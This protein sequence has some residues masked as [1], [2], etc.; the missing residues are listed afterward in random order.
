M[1]TPLLSQSVVNKTF[2]HRLTPISLIT[3]IYHIC[4]C[5]VGIMFS[6]D[7]NKLKSLY[8]A[9]RG[10]GSGGSGGGGDPGNEPDYFE[11]ITRNRAEL[12]PCPHVRG[13]IERNR[14]NAMMPVPARI[15]FS[16]T[17]INTYLSCPKI[18]EVH[19]AAWR[20]SL[21]GVHRS[22]GSDPGD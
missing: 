19:S 7:Q 22:G 12:D 10:C 15:T 4:I 20:S 2:S 8:H 1:A 6:T 9:L 17:S 11:I 18:A 13:I 3:P 16:V 14:S 5:R 21:Q